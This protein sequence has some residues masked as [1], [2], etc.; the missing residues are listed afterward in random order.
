MLRLCSDS[1]RSY[2]GRPAR[3]GVVLYDS[4]LYGNM[5]GDRAGVSRCHSRHRKPPLFGGVVGGNEPG[6]AGRTH[7]AEGPNSKYGNRPYVLRNAMNPNGRANIR[8]RRKEHDPQVSTC[9]GRH[10]FKEL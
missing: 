5:Q 6:E 4:A 7:P 1:S 9:S 8:A 2:P 10:L 3:R